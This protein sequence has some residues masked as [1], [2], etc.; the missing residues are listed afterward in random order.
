VNEPNHISCE[1]CGDQVEVWQAHI[2]RV[3]PCGS[4]RAVCVLCR[5]DQYKRQ[6]AGKLWDARKENNHE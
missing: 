2:I 4:A 5:N 3:L 6:R 1:H